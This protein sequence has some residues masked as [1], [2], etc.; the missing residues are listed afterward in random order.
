MTKGNEPWSVRLTARATA[1]YGRIIEWTS[2]RFGEKQARIYAETLALALGTLVSGPTTTGVCERADI[3][4]GLFTLHVARQGR[5]G[6]HFILFQIGSRK[7]HR[8][9]EVLRLLHDAMDLP[10]QIERR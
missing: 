9:I 3:A 4:R 10:S 6:R 7:A 1:D 2:E 5:K 8:R